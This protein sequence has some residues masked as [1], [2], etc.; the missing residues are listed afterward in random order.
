M[1]ILKKNKQ[2]KGHQLRVK[3]DKEIDEIIC[4]KVE[5]QVKPKTKNI[6]TQK[7]L[8]RVTMTNRKL[9]KL[10]KV[11]NFNLKKKTRKFYDDVF[12]I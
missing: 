6:E 5:K 12:D 1:P 9:V 4:E 3:D 8:E 7:N 2:S 11:S 10:R